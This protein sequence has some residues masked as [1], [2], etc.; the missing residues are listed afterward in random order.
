MGLILV[1]DLDQTIIDSQQYFFQR[2]ETYESINTLKDEIL[3]G[4]YLN[5][6]I[7]DILKRASKLRDEDVTNPMDKKVTAIFLLTNNSDPIYVAAVDSAIHE[8]C[9]STGKYYTEANIDPDTHFMP[10]KPYFFDSIMM[11]GHSKRVGSDPS[12][13]LNDVYVML[14]YLEIKKKPVLGSIYFFDDIYHEMDRQLNAFGFPDH[15]IKITPAFRRGETD[16]TNYKPILDRLSK[17]EGADT[18]STVAVSSMAPV[19][20]LTVE[21]SKPLKAPGRP[22]SGARNSEDP[23]TRNNLPQEN[24]NSLPP[25]PLPAKRPSIFGVWPE[26]KASQTQGG[27]RKSRIRKLLQKNRNKT[28]NR[29]RK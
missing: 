25:L 1:F 19:S 21:R 9:N 15:S 10:K 3:T 29:I 5:P 7:I 8:L 18:T 4:G 2:P 27:R 13:S 6:T 17:L 23:L 28:R 12:K 24:L 16:L 22:R 26:L 14:R 20:A 11:R